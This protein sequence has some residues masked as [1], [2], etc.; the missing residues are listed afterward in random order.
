MQVRPEFTPFGVTDPRRLAPYLERRGF[1]QGECLMRQGTAGGECYLIEE[2]EVRLEVERPDFDSD[3]VI[4]YLQAGMLCGEFS[5]L[6]GRPRSASAYAHTDVVA[7]RLS[8]ERLRELCGND[9]QM[10]LAVL[11]ALGQDAA[12]KAR[13][14]SST[15]TGD[16]DLHGCWAACR[17]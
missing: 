3:G 13:Q 2:G 12:A 15:P 5:F 9:P 7:S 16:R 10:G 14:A 6:D 17:R 1:A 4:T 8:G 11:R